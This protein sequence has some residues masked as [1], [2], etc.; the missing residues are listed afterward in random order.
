MAE[1]IHGAFFKVE[2]QQPSNIKYIR[3]TALSKR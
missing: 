1:K 3:N 2:Y